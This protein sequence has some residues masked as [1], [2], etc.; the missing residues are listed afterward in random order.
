MTLDPVSNDMA[1]VNQYQIAVMVASSMKNQASLCVITTEEA[2]TAAKQL[3]E[4]SKEFRKSVESQRKE[5]IE[6]W[7]KEISAVNDASKKITEQL[8]E[9]EEILKQKIGQYQSL[10]EI[11]KKHEIEV[12]KEA[13]NILGCE[14]PAQGIE[15]KR[16]SREGGVLAY[17]KIEKKFKV[18]EALSVPRQFLK[19]DEEAIQVAIKQGCTQIPGIEIYEEQKTVLRSR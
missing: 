9:A 3:W 19:V 12:Q 17:T 15:E 18:V 10:L 2:E 7:R 6:P 14:L 11:E 4:Q 5:K 8:E 16:I 13:A 1:S